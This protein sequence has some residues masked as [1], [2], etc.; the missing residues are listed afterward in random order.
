LTISV[1]Q[2]KRNL[3]AK[4]S[5]A[6]VVSDGDQSDDHSDT[7]SVVYIK[8]KAKS[9]DPVAKDASSKDPSSKNPLPKDPSTGEAADAMAI[10]EPTKVRPSLLCTS[11][12]PSTRTN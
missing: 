5:P 4:S 6:V 7:G 1:R 12:R 8:A 2:T 10:D 9:K 3:A 11:A